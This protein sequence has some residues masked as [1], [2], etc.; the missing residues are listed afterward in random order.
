M[1]ATLHFG[2]RALVV[3]LTLAMATT[4]LAERK[5][6]D[7]VIAIV[8]DDVILESQLDARVRTVVSRLNAQGTRMPP[9]EI[10]EERVLE[11]LVTDAIQLQRAEQMGIRISDNEL[12]DTMQN[13]AARNNMT[14]AQF[15]SQLAQE[16]L[17]YREA[18]EQIRREM[19]ISRVQQRQVD[20]RVRVTE[21]EVENF[22]AASAGQESSGVE[23][24][25]AH[26]LVA[27]DDFNDDAEV[28][29]AREKAESL[30][31]AIE[32]GRDF[33]EVAVAESDASNALE[34]GVMGWRPESQLPSLVADVAPQ[35]EVG[36]PSEVLRSGSGFHIVTVLDKRG[37]DETMVEQTRARHI[38]IRPTDTVSDTKAEQRIGEIYQ[39]LQEGTDFAAL[40]RE[41]SDDP[42]SGSDGGN[43]GWVSKGQMV[44][45]FE[46]ALEEA[47]VGELK[48]PF[49][50]RFGWHILEVLERRQKDI[51]GELKEAEARQSLYRRKYEVE[52]QTWLRE[53]RDEAYVEFKTDEL[54]DDG[55]S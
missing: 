52:L 28:T 20:N 55:Q 30:L 14:L 26:I 12:N 5:K 11:Q 13:I 36:E 31:D 37:G 51:G 32:G 1:K 41:V 8:E 38:L 16:G 25:L 54:S 22:M 24:Q 7:S 19:L 49:R 50:S 34:G 3:L 39:Q 33:R 21:R 23:Y 48:G 44:P 43:L 2:A 53:V 18:R 40:A 4:T 15:E 42:V 45:A 17:T 46:T 29:E 27:V 47:E 10:L 6:L 35:L 9:R